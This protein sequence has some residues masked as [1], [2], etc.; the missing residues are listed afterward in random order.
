MPVPETGWP[1]TS[2]EVSPAERVM[3]VDAPL[4]LPAFPAAVEPVTGP[5]VMPVPEVIA[6][7]MLLLSVTVF[8]L[9]AVI[10]PRAVAPVATD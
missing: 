6:V 5:K 4:V 7:P 9:I 2:P 1:G 8:P 10:T 3:V